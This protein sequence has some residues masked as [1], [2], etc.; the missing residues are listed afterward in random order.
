MKVIQSFHSVRIVLYIGRS[1]PVDCNILILFRDSTHWTRTPNIQNYAY[2]VTNIKP[3]T[4]DN[5]HTGV[6]EPPPVPKKP[7]KT[8]TPEK[9]QF[10]AESSG[11]FGFV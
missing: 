9:R 1:G 10:E 7:Q 11:M 5:D 2:S 3:I 6:K 4:S 8:P